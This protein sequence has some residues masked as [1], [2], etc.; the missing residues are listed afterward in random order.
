M[1][2][3]SRIA[4]QL[5]VSQERLSFMELVS[6]TDRCKNFKCVIPLIRN[7]QIKDEIMRITNKKKSFDFR[8]CYPLLKKM[9]HLFLYKITSYNTK[10]ETDTTVN[11]I[12]ITR[13]YAL[14]NHN[15]IITSDIEKYKI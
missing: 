11:H 3:S 9:K 5:A 10:E 7:K 2:G 1:L 8:N 4:A 13:G 12:L 6:Y 15:P 14:L